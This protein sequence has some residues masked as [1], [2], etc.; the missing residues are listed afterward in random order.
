MISEPEI[1]FVYG[2]LRRGSS[3]HFRM[4][5]AKFVAEA[6]VSGRLYRV[7]W[8][9]GM[10]LDEAGDA[11]HGDVYEVDKDTLA[12]LDVFEGFAAGEVEGTEYRRLR[13]AVILADKRVVEA[14]V[15]E[16]IGTTDEI[17]RL[18]NGDW[19]GTE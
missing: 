15:W 17:K 9:P 12:I 2:T 16:W 6:T 18:S 1:V 7:H 19:L 11:I 8:Y 10:V 14:W 4:A 3:D 13:T 5:A